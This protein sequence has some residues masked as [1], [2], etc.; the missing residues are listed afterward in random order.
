MVIVRGPVP[1]LGQNG[2]IQSFGSGA[3]DLRS[4]RLVSVL[5]R[6]GLGYFVV[7]I[8]LVMCPHQPVSIFTRVL[9]GQ[10]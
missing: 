8:I 1:V 10:Y 6:L 5:G 3:L 2:N 4:V 9:L 7:A